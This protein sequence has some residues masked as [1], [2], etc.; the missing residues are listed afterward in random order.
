MDTGV[1]V[2]IIA[3]AIILT[4]VVFILTYIFR[5]KTGH[6]NQ[7]EIIT[8]RLE[9]QKK[10]AFYLREKLKKINSMDNLFFASMIRLTSRLNNRDIA[11]EIT[12]LLTNYLD[13]DKIAVFLSDDRGERLK[14]VDQRGLSEDWVH[15]IIYELH[16][17]SKRGKVGE[18]FDKKLPISKHEFAVL[19]V[20][21]PL[22]VFNPDICYPLFYQDKKF[23]V[24][25][26]SLK[27]DLE[28]RER[29][30]LGVVS[31]IAG[32]TLNNTRTA[33]ADPLT[34]LYN[35]GYFREQLDNELNRARI[36]QHNLSVAIIDLDNFKIYNDTY[37]HQ[38]G[39]LLL[40]RL[41]QIF[42]K[43]FDTE[44][45]IAR[46]GGDEFILMIPQI[47]KEDTARIIGRLLQ[48]FKKY[49]FA[50][51]QKKVNITFSAG[52][53]SYPDD[54]INATELMRLADQALY[55]A[56]REGRNRVKIYQ[57]KIGRV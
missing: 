20:K 49:D 9:S 29:N 7:T 14:I 19:G 34:Q 2:E 38:A 40:M 35:I 12:G 33:H 16:D 25:T 26:I 51:G 39:D 15:K 32:I 41:A 48:E 1:F 37:G 46:Y 53:A 30:L 50:R 55:E 47:K 28:E 3:G 23:G 54:A 44:E 4:I 42:I 21:E 56:K 36:D 57:A 24:I 6:V 5:R 17:P 43:H 22:P 18:C 45:T 10:D 52:V 11:K 13:A 8:E 27:K 31:A